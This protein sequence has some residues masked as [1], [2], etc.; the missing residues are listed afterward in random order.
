MDGASHVVDV[1]TDAAWLARMPATLATMPLHPTA[2]QS[3]AASQ[4]AV[5]YLTGTA[6]SAAATSK[7]NR[8]RYLKTDWQDL[9]PYPSA[10]QHEFVRRRET[11]RHEEVM[12]EY[13]DGVSFGAAVVARIL[14]QHAPG[15][16]AAGVAAPRRTTSAPRQHS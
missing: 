4:A 6:D 9:R 7:A 3:V 12:A 1:I 16:R 10:T 14:C 15:A 11:G 13:S 5:E 8:P 2:D